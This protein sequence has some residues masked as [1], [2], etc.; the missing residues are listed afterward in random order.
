MSSQTINQLNIGNSFKQ[1]SLREQMYTYYLSQ[2]AWSGAKI[3]IKQRSP[4]S[5]K[6]F[7][8]LIE[9]FRRHRNNKINIRQVSYQDWEHLENYTML[10]FSN[11]GNYRAF[12]KTKFVTERH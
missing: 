11:L 8:F 10:L 5:T 1:L 6:I 3:T 12:F 2:A 4:E 7:E 9:F